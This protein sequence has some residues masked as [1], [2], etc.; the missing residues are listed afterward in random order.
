MSGVDW[1]ALIL[2]AVPRGVV[3]MALT[4]KFPGQNV[5]LISTFHLARISIVMPNIPWIVRLIIRVE[6]HKNKRSQS[7]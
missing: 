2:G 5:V 7:E 3:E 1:Q 4:A 6:Q